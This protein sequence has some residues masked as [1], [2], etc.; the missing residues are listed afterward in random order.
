MSNSSH[1]KKKAGAPFKIIGRQLRRY[2]QIVDE[3]T[4]EI[5][6]VA[7]RFQKGRLIVRR[8]KQPA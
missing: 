8:E 3:R 4:G 6:A 7:V 2:D 5:L 1:T